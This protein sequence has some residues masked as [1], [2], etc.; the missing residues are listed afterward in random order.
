VR[1][2]HEQAGVDMQVDLDAVAGDGGQVAVLG[3][4]DAALLA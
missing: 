4:G 1:Q 3:I 2:V